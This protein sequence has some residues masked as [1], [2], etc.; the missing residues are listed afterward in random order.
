MTEN[1]LE[2]MRIL[3]AKVK[4]GE[5]AETFLI[6]LAILGSLLVLGLYNGATSL[7]TRIESFKELGGEIQSLKDSIERFDSEDWRDVVPDVKQGIH[8]LEEEFDS[9]ADDANQDEPPERE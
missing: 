6:L 7:N 5:R 3:R 8:D 1:E 9:K 4:R 2:E